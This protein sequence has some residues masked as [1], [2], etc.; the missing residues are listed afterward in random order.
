MPSRDPRLETY[1]YKEATMA[2]QEIIRVWKAKE[3]RLS[4]SKEQRAVRPEPQAG[5]REL[6]ES[7]L[8]GAV[9]GGGIHGDVIEVA[10]IFPVTS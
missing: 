10:L 3:Y 9:G 5:L 8:D 7:E 2:Y 4:L 6:A 1:T